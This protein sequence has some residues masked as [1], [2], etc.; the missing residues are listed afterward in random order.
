MT[1]TTPGRAR[2]Q[3]LGKRMGTEP[4]YTIVEHTDNL[5]VLHSR[6]GANVNAGRMFIAVGGI[7]ILVALAL[8]CVGMSTYLQG[9]NIG[10]FLVSS[11][12][13]A[14][15]GV[16]G[17]LGVVGGLSITRTTNT[18][19]VDMDTRTITYSQ[20]SRRERQQFLDFDQIAYLRLSTQPFSSAFFLK[21][22]QPIAVLELITNE[23]VPWLVDSAADVSSIEP[24]AEALSSLLDVE[25]RRNLDAPDR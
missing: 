5:L 16:V 1:E 22:P 8:F 14:P 19:T 24:V 11:L 17:L 25:V 7:L 23:N 15:C 2:R 10:L 12:V 18:I 13:S 9:V 20:K 21:R 6:P 3:Q 4:Y